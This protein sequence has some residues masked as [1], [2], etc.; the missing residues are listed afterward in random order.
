MMH[1]VSADR[2]LAFPACT[3]SPDQPPAKEHVV[4]KQNDIKDLERRLIAAKGDT[5]RHAQVR[6]DIRKAGLPHLAAELDRIAESDD[7]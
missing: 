6:Q 7:R 1:S 3:G 5:T 4:A 2:T